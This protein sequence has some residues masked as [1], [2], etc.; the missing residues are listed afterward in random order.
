[1]NIVAIN[2]RTN[3]AM[4]GAR[5]E[6]KFPDKRYCTAIMREKKPAPEEITYWA[7]C[8]CHISIMLMPHDIIVQELGNIKILLR[9]EKN[10][11]LPAFYGYMGKRG[12]FGEKLEDFMLGFIIMPLISLSVLWFIHLADY[13]LLLSVSEKY[14]SFSNPLRNPFIGL[15]VVASIPMIL[16]IFAIIFLNK[17]KP[18][19]SLGAVFGSFLYY[20]L[21]YF[22]FSFGIWG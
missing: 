2:A 10:F 12:R 11:K 18:H 17:S 13:F 1:M 16:G 15:F 19:I 6:V 9:I 4:I 20:L 5:R 21:I 3:E 22:L 7:G 8:F 14:Y